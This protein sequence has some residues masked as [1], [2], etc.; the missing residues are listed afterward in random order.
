MPQHTP[1]NN[2]REKLGTNTG[3]LHR[4]EPDGLETDPGEGWAE[5]LSMWHRESLVSLWDVDFWRSMLF[6]GKHQ[7]SAC[8]PRA[9]LAAERRPWHTSKMPKFVCWKARQFTEE[10]EQLLRDASGDS[11]PWEELCDLTLLPEDVTVW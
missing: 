5:R 8:V 6:F 3:S 7:P 2:A 1:K 11:D 4:R 9:V 10:F